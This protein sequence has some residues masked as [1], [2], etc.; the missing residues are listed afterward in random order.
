MGISIYTI[1]GF[2]VGLELTENEV[3]GI[4]VGYLLLDLGIIRIQFAW[5]QT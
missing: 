2:Q 5:Y 4:P 3:N 1:C